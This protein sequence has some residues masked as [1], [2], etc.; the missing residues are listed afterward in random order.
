MYK[1]EN[2]VEWTEGLRNAFKHGI[3]RAKI[4]YEGTIITEDTGIVDVKIEDNRYVPD[5]G[6]IGQATAK[7]ATITLKD[8]SGNWNF[9]NQEFQL[10]IGADYENSTYYINYGNFIVNESPE[11]D[12][13]AETIKLIAFDYM[14]RFNK[15]YVDNITYPCTMKQLLEN[16]CTQANV[17]LGTTSFANDDFIVEDNQFEGKTLREVLQN[18][19]KSAFSWARI[20]QDNKLYLDLEVSKTNPELSVMFG[21]TSQEGTPTP[22]SPI[23]VNVVTGENNIKV[24]K[25]I[26]LDIDGGTKTIDGLTITQNSDRSVTL[27]GIKYGNNI[28]DFSTLLRTTGVNSSFNN[29]TLIAENPAGVSNPVVYFDILDIAQANIGKIIN[30]KCDSITNSNS[31][32]RWLIHIR[33]RLD[34]SSTNLSSDWFYAYNQPTYGGGWEIPEGITYCQFRVVIDNRGSSTSEANILTIIKPM[35]YLGTED[36]EYEPYGYPITYDLS[37]TSSNI[38]PIF[39]FKNNADYVLSGVT[40]SLWSNFNS[41]YTKTHNGVAFT[42]NED[43]SITANGTATAIAYSGN[44][45]DIYANGIYKILPAGT[46]TLSKRSNNYQ[47]QVYN[48]TTST[49][50]ASI[51][52]SQTE[53]TF[54]LTE[55]TTIVIRMRVASGVKINETTNFKLEEGSQVTLGLSTEMYNQNALAYDGIDGEITKDTDTPVTYIALS[56]PT[57][58]TFNNLTLYPRLAEKNT[59]Q[60]YE[61]NLGKNLLDLSK[62][63]LGA[64]DSSGSLVSNNQ[65]WRATDYIKVEPNTTYT[66]SRASSDIFTYLRFYQYDENYNFISPRSETGN[67]S[68]SI[69]TGNN[70]HYLKW[71]VY[72]NRDLMT[73][74]IVSSLNLQIEK[75]STATSYAPYFKPIELCKTDTNQDKIFRQDGKWY[76]YEE[77]GKE[78]YNGDENITFQ[79]NNNNIAGF[80]LPTT[81]EVKINTR[82]YTNR[83]KYVGF[84]EY[85]SNRSYGIIATH[86]SSIVSNLYVSAPNN[87]I[88]DVDGFKTW[89]ASNSIVA[90]YV[91]NTPTITEITNQALIDQLEYIK[92]NLNLYEGTNYVTLISN[93]IN[94][95][96]EFTLPKGTLEVEDGTEIIKEDLDDLIFSEI[97]TI[98]EYEK[99]GFKKANEYVGGINTVVY[100]Q[101]NISGQ[102][103]S[104]QDNE[105]VEENGIKQLV[106]NDN[107]FAYTSEKR[108]ALVQAGTRLFGLQYMPV[109]E[110]KTIGFAYLDCT[111]IVKVED[112]DENNY[113]VIPFNHTIKYNGVLYDSFSSENS[114]INEQIYENKNTNAN[115][116]SQIEITVDRAL[117][118]IRSIVKDVYEEDGVIQEQFTQVYQDVRNIINTVQNAGGANL[119]KNSV[120]FALDAE[121]EPT[122]WET[123]GTG[124]IETDTSAE[125]LSNGGIS[126]HIFTLHDLTIKQTIAVT[127]DSETITDK[128]YYSFACRVLKGLTGTGYVKIYNDVE[129][130]QINIE[131]NRSYYYE[132]IELTGLLPKSNYYIIEVY[133][134]SEGV[135]FTDLMLNIGEYKTQWQQ[136]SGEIM[137]T[138]VNIN[139]D[140]VLVKSSVYEGDY[141]V[142]SPLE[143]AGYS[144]INGVMTKVFSLNKDTTEME[145]IK[146]VNGIEMPPIKVIP[147]LTGNKQGWAFVPLTE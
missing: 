29:D 27:D 120:M 30:F 111:D 36:K 108:S 92:N 110:L 147:I 67:D 139:I 137:N 32:S 114:S 51:T 33:Y 107:Y 42:H 125:A 38:N 1:L 76:L 102:E 106:I 58:T 131:N 4:I 28:V 63:E 130:Y 19:A 60:N 5:M 46:Y 140:G 109:Q 104:V 8:T 81:N 11:T 124:T 52:A 70:T 6:F 96:Y 74:D 90:Y 88:T 31:N 48:A 10:L 100:G 65:N 20:G 7:R 35:L 101:S 59:Y 128:T 69:T 25:G 41:T 22:D 85:Y 89:L 97:I 26:N 112:L 126:G 122:E 54:A 23:N 43:G 121:G 145:K 14:L 134:S 13:T 53:I 118:E 34:G 84:N 117:K 142:M 72:Q 71:T 127:A 3:T 16:I 141:T 86:N 129:E 80:R 136:A 21:N 75:G 98:D 116:A 119:I 115:S 17:E 93:D 45:A 37:K 133:G 66:Y 39:T 79:N 9:E 78:L 40:K 18:I 24:Q 15:D 61:I 50:I 64:I 49:S 123:T 144:K 47:L 99:D 94:A 138:Q 103:E 135:T 132:Q 57:N 44:I 82:I 62:S 87:E 105:D 113:Y 68:L 91:L 77:I 146:V 83:C 55:E 73:L 143:F 2:N 12:V 56:I 95:T